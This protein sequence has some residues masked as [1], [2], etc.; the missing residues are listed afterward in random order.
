MSRSYF[1]MSVY[2]LMPI[3]LASCG[4][5]RPSLR[6]IRN[7]FAAR[8]L[9]RGRGYPIRVSPPNSL[10]AFHVLYLRDLRSQFGKD[11]K[12]RYETAYAETEPQLPDQ[13]NLLPVA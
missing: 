5:D 11:H 3:R 13:A 10:R 6:R 7:S 1:D 2:S 12:R 8:R 4:C 9:G